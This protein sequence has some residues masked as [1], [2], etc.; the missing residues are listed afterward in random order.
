MYMCILC[1]TKCPNSQVPPTIMWQSL[2]DVTLRAQQVPF[3]WAVELIDSHLNEGLH[4]NQHPKLSDQL[5]PLG[6][7]IYDLL[8]WPIRNLILANFDI[9]EIGWQG[10][11]NFLFMAKSIIQHKCW[12][13]KCAHHLVEGFC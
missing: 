6:T 11:C 8:R 2:S 10:Y 1:K 3:M 9:H 12:P 5:H 4:G 7:T 13:D